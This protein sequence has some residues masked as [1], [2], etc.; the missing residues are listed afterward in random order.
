MN[1]TFKK[2]HKKFIT[3]N[4]KIEQTC[5]IINKNFQKINYL[6]KN[7]CLNSEIIC[8]ENLLCK[9]KL[10]NGAYEYVTKHD[11]GYCNS[12]KS[13]INSFNMSLLSDNLQKPQNSYGYF[14]R[15]LITGSDKE[16]FYNYIDKDS[17]ILDGEKSASFLLTL[18]NNILEDQNPKLN[19]NELRLQLQNNSNKGFYNRELFNEQNKIKTQ[20]SHFLKKSKLLSLTNRFQLP[21]DEENINGIKELTLKSMYY[22]IQE[23][24]FKSLSK[25]ELDQSKIK[26]STIFNK[27]DDIK[28]EISKYLEL[29]NSQFYEIKK[30]LS[31]CQ[32]KYFK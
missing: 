27:Q 7:S 12:F 4:K 19:N 6:Y 3:S 31:F 24:N 14:S 21:F 32:E 25:V 11:I 15:N 28:E 1:R 22:K 18:S 5:K 9:E 16:F 8:D 23:S 17:F 2:L 29:S 13:Q 26:D 20:S 10:I 30:F